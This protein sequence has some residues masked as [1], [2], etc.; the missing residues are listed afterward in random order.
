MDESLDWPRFV[1]SIQCTTQQ[2]GAK[3]E[4]IRRKDEEKYLKSSDTSDQMVR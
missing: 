3:A 1:T 4:K 2:G